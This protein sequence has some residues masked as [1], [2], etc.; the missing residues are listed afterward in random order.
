MEVCRFCSPH[1]FLD[2]TGVTAA[3]QTIN[4]HPATLIIDPPKALTTLHA[5][6]TT[7]HSGRNT[8]RNT[9]CLLVDVKRTERWFMKALATPLARSN[10]DDFRAAL[11]IP[12]RH[13]R[14]SPP[15]DRGS[16]LR[17]KDSRDGIINPSNCHS[18]VTPRGKRVFL[19]DPALPFRAPS[20][21]LWNSSSCFSSA[22]A[23]S[24]IAAPR[25]R[26]NARVERWGANESTTT[27]GDRR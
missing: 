2:S 18:R 13:R 10:R 23:A 6:R 12:K 7:R 27:V 20:N 3:T 9:S 15:L 25:Y 17:G 16:L 4:N 26:E 21:P 1:Q 14:R 8:S 5:C 22:S 11:Q 19:R 24:C